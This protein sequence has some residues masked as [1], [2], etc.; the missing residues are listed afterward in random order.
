MRTYVESTLGLVCVL[1][2]ERLPGR[3][4]SISILNLNGAGGLD[5]QVSALPLPLPSVAVIYTRPPTRANY[6]GM[7]RGLG[8]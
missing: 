2:L 6:M 8:D 4:S 7:T 3:R 5:L 1:L